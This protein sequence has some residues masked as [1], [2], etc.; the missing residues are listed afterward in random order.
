MNN[1]TARCLHCGLSQRQKFKPCISNK[2]HDFTRIEIHTYE[3][4]LKAIWEARQ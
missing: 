4:E 2:L 3:N 1:P